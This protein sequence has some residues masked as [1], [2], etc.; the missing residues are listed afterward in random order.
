M[1]AR[2]DPSLHV[3]LDIHKHPEERDFF[4]QRFFSTLNTLPYLA[5]WLF[6]LAGFPAMLDSVIAIWKNPASPIANTSI[7]GAYSYPIS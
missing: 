2:S 6:H 3:S 1:E 4:L 7:H 5:I